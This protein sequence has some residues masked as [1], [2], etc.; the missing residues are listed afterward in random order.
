ME[1]SLCFLLL[2][3]IFAFWLTPGG[4]AWA[5]S[6]PGPKPN[7]SIPGPSGLPLLG[8][9]LVFKSKLT[10][11]HLKNLSERFK[12]S[13]VMAFSVGFTRFVI[14]SEPET[15][16][17]ILNSSAFADRPV[18]ESAYVL[19]F[20]RAMGFAPYGVYWRHLRR[21]SAQHMFSPRRMGEFS[22]VRRELGMRMVGE[23]GEK[24]KGNSNGVVMGVKRVL[25]LGALGNV[26]MSVFGEFGS[27]EVES[28][29]REGYELLGMFNWSDHFGF[30]RWMDLQ[31]VT[32]RCKDLASRVEPFVGRIVQEHRLK[33]RIK[34]E[35]SNYDFVDVLLDLE[36]NDEEDGN[37]LS[38]SDMVAVLWV[39]VT[40]FPIFILQLG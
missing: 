18:K 9:A 23:I 15:A 30:L 27:E 38:H 10:H 34:Q 25:F 22:G 17:E 24:M 40:P 21:I 3:G 39:S 12:A 16:K 2:L 11:R 31:G 13:S 1:V 28:L 32:R 33:R 20:R 5:L 7:Q 35:H 26:M 29:V 19:M 37:G 4:L 14:A 8:L 6:K 36:E